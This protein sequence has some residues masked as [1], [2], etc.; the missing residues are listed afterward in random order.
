[1]RG[2][3]N[4]SHKVEKWRWQIYIQKKREGIAKNNYRSNAC[5]LVTVY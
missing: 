1:M 4:S 5:C 2:I 3:Y